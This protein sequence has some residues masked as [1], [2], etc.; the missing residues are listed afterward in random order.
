MENAAKKFKDSDLEL[1]LQRK[2]QLLR[3]LM[4]ATFQQIASNDINLLERLSLEK[5]QHLTEMKRLDQMADEW[6]RTQ[7]RALNQREQNLVADMRHLLED[8]MLAEENLEKKLTREKQKITKEMGS[9][10]QSNHV[11]QYLGN[12]KQSG[13]LFS[14]QR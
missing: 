7:G 6:A 14:I 4:K 3:A 13:S 10:G 8:L 12:K 1:I 9:L 11:K 2:N 5:Q